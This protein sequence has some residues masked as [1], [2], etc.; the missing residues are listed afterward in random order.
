MC[1]AYSTINSLPK[2]GKVETANCFIIVKGLTYT[3]VSSEL[4]DARFDTHTN[5]WLWEDGSI[6]VWCSETKELILYPVPKK[7]Y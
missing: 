1:L 2:G 5:T 7:G 6:G 4:I 3:T